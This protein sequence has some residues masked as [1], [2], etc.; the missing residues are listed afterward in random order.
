MSLFFKECKKIL[1]SLTFV[2]YVAVVVV[3]YASQFIS[4]RKPIPLPQPGQDYYGTVAREVPEILMPNAIENLVYETMRGSYTAYPIGFYRDVKLSGEKK[5]QM[6]GIIQEL[7]GLSLEELTRQEEQWGNGVQVRIEG[8]SA[9][10]YVMPEEQLKPEIRIPEELSYARFRELM[11]EA[12]RLIGGGSQYNEKELVQNFSRVPKTYEV[13]LEEYN[14]S[15][16]EE[17]VSPGYARLFCDYMGIFLAVMPVFVAAEL[18]SKDRKSRMEQ[19]VYSRSISS[20]KLLLTRFAALIGVLLVPV[21]LVGIH[22]QVGVY[23][24]YPGYDIDFLAF[25]KYISMWLLPN[26]LVASA[27]GM[28]L[29][30]LAGPIAA[31]FA[32]GAWWFMDMFS[33]TGG[34]SGG[35]TRFVLVPRHNS[36]QKAELFERTIQ[37]FTFN[38]IFYSCL[39]ILAIAATVAVYNIKRKGGLHEIVRLGKNSGR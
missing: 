1:C 31:I 25:P 5:A 16:Y 8:G 17:K 2:L 15:I 12:D 37:E 26:I 13:A 39:A 22:A 30:E 7:T 10:P 4:D 29:T 6:Y 35:I 3:M 21:I 9:S 32:L 24:L 28:L 33:S 19:L 23:G 11:A 38:R 27:L 18:T 36:L 14:K 34:L 20:A